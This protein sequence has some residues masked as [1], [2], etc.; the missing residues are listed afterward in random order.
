VNAGA[1]DYRLGPASAAIDAGVN[2]GISIDFEGSLRPLGG[3]FDIG[4]D[5][6]ISHR[7]YVPLVSR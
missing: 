4:F 7:A 2:A 6:A 5:E 1:D 3:G